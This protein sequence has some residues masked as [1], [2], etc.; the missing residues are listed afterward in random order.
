VSG[1]LH[2]SRN[3]ASSLKKSGNLPNSDSINCCAD[4]GVP[5]GCQNEVA[6]ICWMLRSFPSA[7][8]TVALLTQR[9]GRCPQNSQGS[10]THT[11]GRCPQSAQG[12]GARFSH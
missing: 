11:H 9:Q 5:S 7:S 10:S 3:S 1:A 12:R 8:F 4:I 2:N 6:T